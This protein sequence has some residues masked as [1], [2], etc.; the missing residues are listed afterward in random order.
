MDTRT[1]GQVEIQLS[2]YPELGLS[3]FDMI[4][5]IADGSVGFGEIYSGFVGGAFP[6]FDV[7]NLWGLFT[8]ADNYFEGVDAISEDY[9]RIVTDK[10]KGGVVVAFNF[11]PSN[12]FF[13]K[14]PLNSLEDFKNLRTRSHS[15][16]LSDLVIELGADPQTMAFAEVYTALERGILDGGVTCGGCGF[17]QKWHEVTKYLTGPVPGSFAQTFLTINGEAWNKLPAEFQ[18]IILEEGAVHT[19]KNRVQAFTWDQTGVDDLVEG[20]MVYSP[21]TPEMTAILAAA[22]E[23]AVLPAWVARAGGYDSEGVQLFNDKMSSVVGL[24]V[25]PDNTVSKIGN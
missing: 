24:K 15:T 14:N 22:G 9:K 1:N 5:L 7:G 12:F 13:T 2:S 6:V 20:G 19:A 8:S 23:K 4:D 18:Q 16:V 25:N 11:Y 21:F 10:T 3:G 17:G